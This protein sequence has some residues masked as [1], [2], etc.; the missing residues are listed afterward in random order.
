[1]TDDEKT[2]D[3]VPVDGWDDPAKVALKPPANDVQLPGG[4]VLR[5]VELEDL[6]AILEELIKVQDTILGA[7]TQAAP[8]LLAIHKLMVTEQ[9]LMLM[10]FKCAKARREGETDTRFFAGLG[11]KKA[12]VIS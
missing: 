6:D 11:G 12:H 8:D 4:T 7:A 5:V 9:R 2:A 10:V 3:D 1:M